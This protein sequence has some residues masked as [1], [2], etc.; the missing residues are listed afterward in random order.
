MSFPERNTEAVKL[1]ANNYWQQ[2]KHDWPT[3]V[4]GLVLPGLGNILV[5]YVPPLIVAKILVAFS[6]DPHPG[7]SSLLPYVLWF[8]GLWLIGE[9][10]WRIAMLCLS[11]AEVR[12]MERLYQQAME[13][14]FARDQAFFNDNFA[15]SL[16][17]KVVGYGSRYVDVMDTLAFSVTSSLI[18]VF[19][20]GFVLWGYSPWLVVALLAMMV[21][22]ALVAIPLIKR[23]AKL[24]AVREAASN[25][26]AGNVAD[27]ISNMTTVRSFAQE[28][29]EGRRHASRVKDHAQKMLKSWDYNT[30]RIEIAL[31]PFFVLTN[32]VGLTIAL[33]LSS[34]GALNVEAIFVSFSYFVQISGFMWKFNQIYRNLE[35]SLTDAAQFTELLIEQPR[36]TDAS[37]VKSLKPVKGLIEFMDV[38]FQYSDSAGRHLF[39]DLNLKINEGEKVA[40]VGH[41]GGGKTTITTLLLRFMDIE[42][43]KILIDGQD[44]SKV[45]QRQLRASIAYVPQDTSLF[46]RSLAD[47]IR[48]GKLDA[49]DDE[50]L[51][52]A[53]LSHAHD[54]IK[55]L[56]KAYE[57]LV[58]ERGVKLSGGQR[59]RIA[60]ARA[61]L[62]DA[63]ILVLD[64]ATSALDSESEKVIQDALWKLMEGKTTIAIAHRLSTI[65]R[66]DRIVVLD[67]GRIAQ[68]GTHKQLLEKGG[69]YA[70]LWAHQSGGFL[71]D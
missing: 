54:F 59:Q 65:S 1:A 64:E 71:E 20:A 70:E 2:L 31:S 38:S 29:Y 16:T 60:I 10:L 36:V 61:I 13:Y 48:Y 19:F 34:N 50:M 23:R 55:E 27:T 47:N 57:T 41:S 52:A 43:G 44:I 51:K 67:E 68:Q 15:G 49:A 39:Q 69:I 40:L 45:P 35:S 26:M 17:K 3:A 5:F 28:T 63:P 42:A 8:T 37:D 14:L 30:L 22:A 12:G 56:P 33:A 6:N 25:V 53:K 4:P 58:G 9:V 18:P 11:R 7:A 24:V 62:K 46:H 66:M 21:I 32:V